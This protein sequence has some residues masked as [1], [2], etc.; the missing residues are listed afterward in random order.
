MTLDK[1]G[2]LPLSE[3][4]SMEDGGALNQGT[5]GSEVHQNP[6]RKVL[7]GFIESKKRG[8]KRR[9]EVFPQIAS[10]RFSV[11]RPPKRSGKVGTT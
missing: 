4:A 8:R 7:L 5:A 11:L 10:H 9:R 2:F 3:S 1:K 6:K